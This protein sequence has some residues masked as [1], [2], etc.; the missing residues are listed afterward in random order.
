MARVKAVFPCQAV[1]VQ[2]GADG[3][4]EDSMK[5][6]NLTH[7]A[8]AKCVCTLLSWKLPTM[9]LGG[10]GYNFPNTA[11][12]WTFLTALAAGKQLPQDIPEHEYLL[13][14]GPSYEISTT[15]G[16]RKDCNTKDYLSRV[17]GQ[18]MDNLGRVSHD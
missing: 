10:G 6:F 11:K 17:V 9:L 15:V 16:N 12:T 4:S 1:V 18:V 7:L 2:C 5:S 3:L 13:E 14:Y 8:L